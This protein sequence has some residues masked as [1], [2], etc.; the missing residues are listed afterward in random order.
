MRAGA[1]RLWQSEP[2]R[3]EIPLWPA[4]V[5]LVTIQ[6]RTNERSWAGRVRS[7]APGNMAVP[8]N[9]IYVA[10]GY[11]CGLQLSHWLR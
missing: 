1:H 11:L 7:S 8:S 6:V 4:D 9:P 10:K 2:H 5:T 3:K